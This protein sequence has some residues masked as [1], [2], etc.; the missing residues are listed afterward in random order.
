MIS[1]QINYPIVRPT[2]IWDYTEEYNVD[3]YLIWD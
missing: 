1:E 2:D 3:P